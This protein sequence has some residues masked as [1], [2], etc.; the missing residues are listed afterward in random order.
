[1]IVG[2][3]RTSTIEP[4]AGLEAQLRD[5]ELAGCERVFTEQV[6]SVDVDARKHLE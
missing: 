4:K 1:M 5:L 3:A 6:S 2:Y